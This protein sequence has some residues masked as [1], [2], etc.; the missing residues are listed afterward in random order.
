MAKVLLISTYEL[1]HQPFG[2]ASPA[3]WLNDAGAD[4]SCLD[5]AVRSLDKELVAQSDLVA[6]YLPMHTATRLAAE[7]IPQLRQFNEAAHLCCYGLYAPTNESFLRRLGVDTIIGG[8]FETGL[9]DLFR[10]LISTDDLQFN[11]G[12]ALV[13]MERQKF[14]VPERSSLP[15]LEEYAHLLLPDG[16]IRKAGYTEATRGCKYTCR[17]C[18]IVPIYNGRFRIVQQEIVLADIRQQVE[19]GAQHISFGDPDFLNGPGHGMAIVQA[20]NAEFPDLSYDV[21]IKVEHLLKHEQHLHTLKDTGCI[22]IT[23]AVEAVDDGILE[24][25]DKGHTRAGFEKATSN[26]REVGII[27][28]PTFVAFT[29][30]TTREG[31]LEMLR[32]IRDLDLVGHVA[33]IQYAIRLLV[34][35]GSRL[36][37]LGEVKRLAEPFDHAALI[38]PWQHPDPVMDQLYERIFRLVQSHQMNQESRISLFN[39]VWQATL[40]VIDIVD[41]T[42]TSEMGWDLAATPMPRMSESWY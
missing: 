26:L 12:Q 23:S 30:W 41:P 19:A 38:Y 36:L 31:Y 14:L 40:E 17:H 1:G 5:L 9:V 11:Q 42:L 34:P 28:N 13:S 32:V 8:E 33:P 6:I 18:P 22:F 15:D 29:P 35:A 24:I 4:V 21:T 3:A 20:L 25:L 2:L 7:L 10:Q 27:L 39:D 16:R 37:E